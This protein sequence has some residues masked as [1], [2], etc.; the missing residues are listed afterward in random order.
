MARETLPTTQRSN[1]RGLVFAECP[2]PAGPRGRSMVPGPRATGTR[3]APLGR[4]RGP[5]AAWS[6][7]GRDRLLREVPVPAIPGQRPEGSHTPPA[8]RAAQAP[9]S[10]SGSHR[11]PHVSCWDLSATDA[12]TVPLAGVHS[13]FPSSCIEQ[14]SESEVSQLC[15]TLCHP[16]DCSPPGSSIHGIFQ[17]R[18]LEWGLPR[19]SSG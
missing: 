10:S 6:A 9:P 5:A 8:P 3:P 19:W 15:P 11:E 13:P 4:T 2:W 12:T 16:L 14:K 7:Q 1:E 18:K 17:A